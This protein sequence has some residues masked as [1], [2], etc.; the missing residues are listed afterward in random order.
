MYTL[1]DAIEKAGLTEKAVV[2]GK[3]YLSRLNNKERV[4]VL[5]FLGQKIDGDNSYDSLSSIAL[6]LQGGNIEDMDRLSAPH[7]LALPVT[8]TNDLYVRQ[9]FKDLYNTIL[10]TFEGGRPYD[11]DVRKH[12]VVTGTS[13]IGKSAFLVYFAIR[14]LAESDDDNPPMLIFHTKRSERCFV[15]GGRSTVRSGNIEDFMPFLSLPDT[16]YLVDSSPDPV[17]D[18]AKTIISASPKTLSSEAQHYQDV[19]KRVSWRYY[20]APWN[21][22]ELKTCRGSVAAFEVVPLEMLEELYLEIGGVPRYVLERPMTVCY[23]QNPL[24]FS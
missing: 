5:G 1:E 6:A 8:G 14:L 17:L 19:D 13:G 20:M 3:L 10:G 24:R 21:L 12:V 11:P 16:W 7:G 15:F 4:S 23:G 9:D 22:E 18:R 2:N